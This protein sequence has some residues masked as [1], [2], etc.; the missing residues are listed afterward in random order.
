MKGWGAGGYQVG[1]SDLEFLPTRTKGA[2]PGQMGE[3]LPYILTQYGPKLTVKKL[4][5]ATWSCTLD[6]FNASCEDLVFKITN[7]GTSPVKWLLPATT[8]LSFTTARSAS[9]K[10]ARVIFSV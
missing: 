10:V 4:S 8:W 7:S 6:D 9:L 3:D 1:P 2:A 5:P